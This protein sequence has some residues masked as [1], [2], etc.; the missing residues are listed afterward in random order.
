MSYTDPPG[1]LL[2]YRPWFLRRSGEW[3]AVDVVDIQPHG[4]GFVALLAGIE[5]R[6]GALAAG[7]SRIGVPAGSFSP[8]APGE[9]YWRDLIGLEVINSDGTAF[10]TV[11]RLIDTGAHDVLVVKGERERLIPFVERYV[12][13]VVPEDGAAAGRLDGLRLKMWIGVVSL[14]PELI[15][16]V[17]AVGVLGR[18][19]QQGGLA[20][21]TFNPRDHARDRHGTV[22]DRPYGGGPGMVMMA[23]P[24][25]ASIGEAKSKAPSAARVVCLS[26]QGTR[27]DQEGVQRLADRESLVLVTGRYEGIDERVLQLAIDEELSI[28]DY[29][30]AGGEL[31]AMVLIDAISR[32]LPG[33]LG[34]SESALSESHLDGLLEYPHYTRPET[35]AGLKSAVGTAERRPCGG[36]RLAPRPGAQAN[37]AAPA[38]PACPPAAFGAGGGP[39]GGGTRGPGRGNERCVETGFSKNSKASS[40]TPISPASRAGDTLVVQV[41]VR[42]GVRERLQAFEG[43]VIARRNRGLNSSFTLRKISHGVGVE[44]TFQAHSPL[45]ASIK[46]KRRGDVRKAKLYY[47]RQR[48]G[49]AARIKEKV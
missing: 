37:L 1:N 4:D 43:V 23:E 39:A 21:E 25:L 10:G 20:I 47:L 2:N 3:Q 26:P 9:Y 33:T 17:A 44:R 27:L 29:V 12:T 24:L 7:G 19:V 15:A 30:L 11:E 36:C 18:A 41:R 35:V 5:D 16:N 13:R 38:R 32:L 14:F 45:I 34:N 42:E 49:R 28:G 48:S 40:S 22:D 31:P 46:V 6:N 8:P